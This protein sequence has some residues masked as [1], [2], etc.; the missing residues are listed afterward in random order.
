ML[1]TEDGRGMDEWREGEIGGD[2]AEGGSGRGGRLCLYTRAGRT[3]R[4]CTISKPQCTPTPTHTR[5]RPAPGHASSA[6][7]T[8]HP[9]H[10]HP[11]SSPQK[12]RCLPSPIPNKAREALGAWELQVGAAQ[13]SI[14]QSI[15]SPLPSSV[16]PPLPHTSVTQNLTF[17]LEVIRSAYLSVCQT[18]WLSSLVSSRLTLSC[19]VPHASLILLSRLA[20]HRPPPPS[21]LRRLCDHHRAPSSFL[22]PTLFRLAVCSLQFAPTSACGWPFHPHS[23]VCMRFFTTWPPTRL[24]SHCR[25][26]AARELR[27]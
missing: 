24:A 21:L 9:P 17:G 14:I 4:G 25:A 20:H 11:P 23:H 22:T 18:C 1:S 8:L 15:P 2:G 12:K 7:S 26:A 16:F 27:A 3:G 13:P 10:L 5:T 19:P 6:P